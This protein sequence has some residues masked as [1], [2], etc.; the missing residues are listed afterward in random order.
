MLRFGQ[1][2]R[3]PR[4][5]INIRDA[6]LPPS[7]RGLVSIGPWF[8]FGH[9]LEDVLNP[10]LEPSSR[11]KY[12]SAIDRLY[13][14]VCEQHGTGCLDRLV[15]E[16][17]GDALEECLLGFFAQLRNELVIE[18][19]DKSHTSFRSSIGRKGN[20]LAWLALSPLN[21]HAASTEP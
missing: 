6:A 20:A 17:D 10:N 4:L 1:K 5:I 14:V 2:P 19:A 11:Q 7:P 3:F 16:A 15:A 9:H 8:V 21:L 12:L 18:N 13:E